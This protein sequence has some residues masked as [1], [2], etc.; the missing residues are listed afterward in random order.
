MP[1]ILVGTKYDL[2]QKLKDSKQ[3]KNETLKSDISIQSETNKTILSSEFLSLTN[4]I[5]NQLSRK[6]TSKSNLQSNKRPISIISKVSKDEI[7]SDSDLIQNKNT[8]EEIKQILTQLNNKPGFIALNEFIK[9]S[10]IDED[11]SEK[12]GSSNDLNTL[13]QSDNG[14][15][16]N[17]YISKKQITKLKDSINAKFYFK[18]SCFDINSI[19]FLMDKAILTAIN[20]HLKRDSKSKY[21]NSKLS[22]KANLDVSND[23]TNQL[24]FS[25]DLILADSQN[26]SAK[27]ETIDLLNLNTKKKS[28]NESKL[29]GSL[30]KLKCFSC[31]RSETSTSLNQI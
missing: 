16:S 31:T 9:L 7:F 5:S 6:S 14:S 21:S 24:N 27:N 15:I 3:N 28:Q 29:C 1:I 12:Q 23:S 22:S 4:S 2:K 26:T 19:R 18:T 10:L 11:V 17:L 13:N 20:F 8:N 30:N 25:S